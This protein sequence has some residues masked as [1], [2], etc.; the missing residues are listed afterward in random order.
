MR[1]KQ[2][3]RDD[4]VRSCLTIA[5]FL[6]L[7]QILVF[8]LLA[9]VNG[10]AQANPAQPG[11]ETSL[12][13]DLGEIGQGSLLFKH[14]DALQQAP[15]LDTHV[16]MKITGM[17]NRVTLVQ[18]FS[19]QTDQW[20][21]GVYVFPLPEDA[22][23]D[24]MRLRVGNRIIE[25]QVKERE[26]AKRTY[27]KAKQQGQRAALT[28][29]ERPNV[30]TTS[31]ANIPPQG[32]VIVEIEYQQLVKY[33]SGVFSLR[34]PMVVGPR[35]IPGKEEITG[36]AGSGWATNTSEVADAAR[37]TPSV[38]R[39]DNP[40]RNQVTLNIDLD[41]G[42]ALEKINSTYHP[43]NIDKQSL[44]YLISLE[45]KTTLANRDFELTWQPT[46]DVVPRAALFTETKHNSHYAMM[47]LLPP[48]SEQATTISR[49]MVY[50]IDTSG[51]MGGQSI[52]QA[53]AAL[54]VALTRL[55]P[56][57][58]FNI[59]QFNSFTSQLFGHSQPVNQQTLA[60]AL[61]YV[62][63]LDADGGT[64]MAT[65]MQAALANQETTQ[66]LRQVIFMTDGSI[67]NEQAL[68]EIIQDKLGQSRLFTVGIGSA[69]NAYFMQ[70]AAN[71]GRGTYTY[72]GKLDEAQTRMD[73]LFAII[74]SP[75]L[76]DIVID[77]SEATDVEMW[78]QKITDLYRGE[79][80]VITARSQQL[81]ATLKIS[82]RIGSQPWLSSIALSGG[83]DRTGV[84]ILW[85]RKKIAGLMQAK[86]D[87]EFDSVKQQIVT[88]ALE[89]HLVSNFTS[90]VAVDVTPVR[91]ADK[92]ID[93]HPVP[94]HLPEGWDYNKVFGQGYP[95]T[96]TD[97]RSQF[98]FG[99]ILM[100]LS[101][102]FLMT[103]RRTTDVFQ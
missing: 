79:P 45:D 3:L 36:F 1:G 82:G 74:D 30:F 89:H 37:V 46:P 12:V 14:A 44:R 87:A 29:Q 10:N 62:R 69:P 95:A 101:I 84:S 42:L 31:V 49:E 38:M 97:A 86:R 57:D 4:E 66:L 75:V 47:M 92:S 99:L 76:K 33:D 18:Q 16:N 64:E 63:S 67:G 20:Q 26:Q 56:G 73:K 71:H 77:W 78:P 102:Y 90:L 53:R 8:T 103:Q 72:I 60:K 7:A 70:R 25:G 9:L 55:R 5:G 24:R 15:L 41:A 68:F 22:A 11:Q 94:V 43:V 19:N 93:N 80:L 85:A 39:E 51:S 2:Q 61:R 59:I 40:R 98:F 81:P 34:F 52:K 96:A 100:L 28:E 35:Y 88:T 50:V 91:P 13:H 48:E 32:S 21:E 17:I 23:V 65:A 54:E 27:E 83:Q 58:Y 6:G